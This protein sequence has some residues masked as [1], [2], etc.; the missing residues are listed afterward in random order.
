MANPRLR[1]RRKADSPSTDTGHITLEHD[2]GTESLLIFRIAGET[3]GLRL[4][5][6]A[7]IT[8]LPEL[9]RMPLVP[10]CLLGLA[11]LRGIVLPVIS[12]RILLQLPDLEANEQ[13]RVVVLR[14]DAPV[15]FLVDRIERLLRVAPDQL[16]PDE[17]G[18]GTIDPTLLDGVIK[19][20]E[21][22]NT[23]KILNPP[24][25]L[26][27]QL[28]QLGVPATG[29]AGRPSVT[30]AGSA[31]TPTQAQVSLLSLS[32]GQQ[33]Y[34]L[35]LDRVREI[36]PLPDHISEMPRPE[37]AVLGVMTLQDRLL[38][39]VSLR[40]LLG[41]PAAGERQQ[42]SKIVVVTLGNGAVGVVA[43]ATRE[44]LRISPDIIDPAPALLTRGEGEAE[45]SSICRVDNGRRLIALLSP[46]QLFRPDL[47][48][49]I[50]AEQ[51]TADDP[52]SQPEASAMAHEQFIIFRLG[53]QDYGIPIAAVAEIARPPE[54]I[55][56]LPKAP[57]FIDG[58][59]NLRGSV[60]PIINLRRRF[61]LDATEHATSQRILILSVG[62][63]AAGFLVDSV[64]EIMKAQIDAIH[65]APEVSQE[66]MRLISRVINLEADGRLV[67]L[68]D[69]AQLLDQVE[70]DVLAKFERSVDPS[71]TAP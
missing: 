34:G 47:V 13:S 61:D 58:V 56:Q 26:A 4:A 45:I 31:A 32:L 6:I 1:T 69:P 36:I 22:K 39:I 20:A 15:G 24:R 16:Q 46:D 53:K 48:R 59:M 28:S 25:L 5:T 8:R 43:D 54:E 35:P 37:T 11:N 23:I 57:S 21:G 68:V 42:R 18:A 50:L 66:Q 10:R 40:A 71:V 60:V 12:L 44:I 62:G 63:V 55:T 30:V 65:P 52:Q 3:F 17:A 49:R 2:I 29:P 64:S 51:G 38:P 7:E 67:L 41:L 27:G 70:A 19:G 9:A 14:G 33:E